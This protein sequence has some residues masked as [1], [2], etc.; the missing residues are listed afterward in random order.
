MCII[1]DES[2]VKWSRKE[3]KAVFLGTYEPKLDDKARLILP[4][5]FRDQLAG[6]VVITPGQEHCLYLFPLAEFERI[7]NEMRQAPVT[8]KQARDYIRIMMADA[9]DQIPDKQGR[10]NIPAKL[11][12]YAGLDKDLAVI[13]VGPRAEIWD[14][15]TW[16]RYRQDQENG[17][18]DIKEEIVPGLL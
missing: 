13:G 4:A 7:Y 18:A 11:R 1:V 6:G 2:G 14:L 5:R 8:H 3:G 9:L 17:L 15:E 10:V 12:Q 16:N